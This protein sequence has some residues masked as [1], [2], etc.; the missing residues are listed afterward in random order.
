MAQVDV[1]DAL[2]SDQHQDETEEDPSAETFCKVSV[3]APGFVLVNVAHG[4]KIQLVL[5][6]SSSDGDWEQN[7]H[8]DTRADKHDDHG[9]AHE[10][11]EEVGI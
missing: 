7:G 8:A 3:L 6:T 4:E 5:S 2:S 10:S 1:E 11:K 9:H